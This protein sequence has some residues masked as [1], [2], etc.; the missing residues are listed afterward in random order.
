VRFGQR[1]LFDLTLWLMSFIC[2]MGGLAQTQAFYRVLTSHGLRRASE[3]GFTGGDCGFDSVRFQLQTLGYP[4]QSTA[5]MRHVAV[6]EMKAARN[7]NPQQRAAFID[8]SSCSLQIQ[9]APPV[10]HGRSGCSFCCS[11]VEHMLT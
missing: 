6:R 8:H 1:A 3:Y 5:V 2:D 11:M 10:V 4:V 7:R 9:T